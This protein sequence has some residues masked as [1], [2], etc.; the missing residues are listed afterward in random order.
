MAARVEIGAERRFT[1]WNKK[2]PLTC[3]GQVCD[4]QVLKN[5][6]AAYIGR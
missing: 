6:G 3:S 5:V 2:K 4:P 1:G